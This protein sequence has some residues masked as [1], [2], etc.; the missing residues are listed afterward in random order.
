M[1]V[2]KIDNEGFETDVD[3]FKYDEVRKLYYLTLIG[4][5]RR[6]NDIQRKKEDKKRT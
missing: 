2:T 4:Y 1:T 3:Y 5:E 6:K